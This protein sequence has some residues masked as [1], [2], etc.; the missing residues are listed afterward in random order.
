M[1]KASPVVQVDD[2]Y[3]FGLT[4]NAW[5]RANK[6]ANTLNT[7]QDQ[8][9][10][11]ELGLN[12][13]QFKWRNHMP[14]IGR[15]F[16][17]DPLAE[18]YVYNSVYAFSENN[19]VVHVELEGLEK[20]PINGDGIASAFTGWINRRVEA[21]ENT[22][23]YIG[24]QV[25]SFLRWGD[26][27]FGGSEVEVNNE[28]AVGDGVI[29]VGDKGGG[30]E[31]GLPTA[32]GNADNTYMEK[33]F[34][35]GMTAGSQGDA[36]SQNNAAKAMAE[37]GTNMFSAIEN[38]TSQNGNSNGNGQNGADSSAKKVYPVD[39]FRT[40]EYYRQWVGEGE[41]FRI[42]EGYTPVNYVIFNTGDSLKIYEYEMDK[43]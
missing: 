10:V 19:V 35:D 23:N 27:K 22:L 25:S 18:D 9:L 36:P 41:S 17:V 43:D 34:L 21:A 2:Y 1:Y 32:D 30:N 15:F 33:D 12:W 42:F 11:D 16:N 20:S 24:D 26:E 5:R 13:V 7:F 8:E 40:K 3:P 31:R 14:D 38:L 6:Q 29:I 37:S 28:Q 39:T 4:Y